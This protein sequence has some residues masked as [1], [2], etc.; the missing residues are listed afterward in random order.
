VRLLSSLPPNLA[1]A[2]AVAVLT[3]TALPTSADSQKP[4][5][6]SNSTQAP[7]SLD[8]AFYKA[9]VEPIFLKARPGHARC[10]SCHSESNRIFHLEKLPPGAAAWT[11]EQ[12]RMNFQSATHLVI[13]GNPDLSP[14]LLHPLAPEAGGDAFH[15]GGRQFA[16]QNDPDWLALAE[17]VRGAQEGPSPGCV[18]QSAARIYVTNSAADTIDVIDSATNKIVQVIRRIELPHGINFSPD[19]SRVYVSNESESALDVIDAQSGEILHKVPLSGRPNNISI[20]KDGRRVVVGIRAAPGALDLID[21]SALTLAKTISVNASVHNVYVTPDGKYAVS[22]SIE[23]QS[24]TVVDL[25]TDQ[26]AWRLKLDRGVRPMAFETNPDGSTRRIFVQLSGFHGF[27]V[28]DF[29]KRD[30]VARIA[31]PNEPGGFGSFEGRSGV[32]SHGIGVAP[33]GKSL[34]VNSTLANAVFE[35]SLPDLNLIGYSAL[36]LIYSLGHPPT[37]AV[38]EW[39]TFTPDSRT[40]YVS[41]SAAR[42]VSAIDTKTLKSIAVIPVGEVPK[43]INTLVLH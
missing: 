23:S 10:Y 43:R 26:V 41:N 35:Y 4:C 42:S 8:F 7:A 18:P 9:N 3:F 1:S 30:E 37:G 11:D 13:P 12:S 20:T 2:L 16:S 36:P 15:S 14:L 31:L 39:I 34:W 6:Q 38:P 22:G 21:T 19:G 27:A 17:W 25:E 32:P 5:P 40:V 24:I 33:D 29:A 28:V